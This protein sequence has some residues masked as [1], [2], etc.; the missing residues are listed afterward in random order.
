MRAFRFDRPATFEAASRALAEGGDVRLKAGGT[1]LLARMKERIDEPD[2]VVGLVDLGPTARAIQAT[3]TGIRIGALASLEDIA[4]ADLV[5]AFAPHLAQAAGEAASPA[6]RRQATLGGNLAQHPRCDYHRHLALPCWRRGATSCPVLEPGAVQ[7]GAAIFGNGAC[8]SAHPSSLAP[9]LGTL[10]AVIRVTGARGEREI[11]FE[12]FWAEPEPGR[13]SDHVLGPDD[14]ITSVD[15]S[16]R[17]VGSGWRVAHH[18]I[19]QRASFDWPLVVAAVAVENVNG[20]VA[21]PSIWLGAV[22]PSPRR[23]RAAEDVLRAGPLTPERVEKAA[24][25]AAA[26]ATPLAG[27]AYKKQLVRVAVKRALLDAWR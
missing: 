27:N 10:D 8:A 19:R 6:L 22:A 4:Q 12:A 3:D 5:R 14:V 11:P 25:A 1:D 15:L 23:A 20:V 13:A 7:E 16:A 2:R 26:D 9:A 24:D 21:Q 17:D 18:E